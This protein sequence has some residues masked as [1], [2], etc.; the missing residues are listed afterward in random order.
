MTRI[1]KAPYSG[2]RYKVAS[3]QSDYIN[4]H[5]QFLCGFI[6]NKHILFI[7]FIEQQKKKKNI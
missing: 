6:K 7:D 3:K 1:I 5:H 2:A 4:T